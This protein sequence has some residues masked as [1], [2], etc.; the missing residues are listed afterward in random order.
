MAEL[1]PHLRGAPGAPVPA[2]DPEDLKAIWRLHREIASQRPGESVGID[3]TVMVGR[4]KPGADVH[5]LA[6]RTSMLQV[7]QR[8]ARDSL[9]PWT[10]N[11]ELD[12]AVF[13]VAADIPMEWIGTEERNR[14]PFDVEELL[15]R[16]R[17]EAT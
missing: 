11:T 6:Y 1:P 15:R 7:L 10:K 5:A 13:R 2:V 4:C 12:D 17:G 9:A 3:N 16:L 14:L 8:V